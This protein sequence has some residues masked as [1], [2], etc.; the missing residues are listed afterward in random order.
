MLG[1]KLARLLQGVG[2]A[3]PDNPT[4]QAPANSTRSSQAAVINGI[5]PKSV[6]T[7]GSTGSPGLAR[8]ASSLPADPTTRRSRKRRWGKTSQQAI[9]AKRSR[10]ESGPTTNKSPES[11]AAAGKLAEELELLAA[12][13][14]KLLGDR[15]AYE[16][17]MDQLAKSRRGCGAGSSSSST[18]KAKLRAHLQLLRSEQRGESGDGEEEDEDQGSS[19]GEGSQDL[20][21][22]G[23]SGRGSG[24]GHE[25]ET[26]RR[27]DG[28]DDDESDDE[29]ED[30]EEDQDYDA[31]GG[32]GA[33][34]K[35]RKGRGRGGGE[36]S[37]GGNSDDHDDEEEEEEEEEEEG[38]GT[39]APGVSRL[40]S[41]GG[42]T[43][44]LGVDT[45]AR[46]VGRELSDAEVAMLA[47]AGKC[48]Y[49]DAPSADE[50]HL[51]AWGSNAKW[52]MRMYGTS[53]A[54]KKP[55]KGSQPGATDIAALGS[56]EAR[57]VGVSAVSMGLTELPPAPNG[58]PE[59][60]VKERLVSRWR[61]VRQE[62]KARGAAAAAAAAAAAGNSSSVV[63]SAGGAAPGGRALDGGD[64]CS[65]QQRSLF[66][67][68]NSYADVHL[69]GRPYPTDASLDAPDPLLDAVLLHCLNHV[70]KT[71]DRIKKNTHSLQQQQQLLERQRVLQ[72]Q[73]Q[74]GKQKKNKKS[75]Q[76]QGQGQEQEQEQQEREEEMSPDAGEVVRKEVEV[77]AADEGPQTRVVSEP[78]PGNQPR[79][80]PGQS[81]GGGFASRL[82]PSA[83]TPRDQGFTRPK[84]LLLLPQR[85]C[86]FRAVRRLVALA[87]KETRSDSVQGKQ[88]FVEQFMD[89]EEG[90][91]AEGN[92]DD[93]ARARVAA[94]PPEHRALFSGNVDDH[95]R[96]GI[97]V[98]KGA[99][100]LFADLYNSDI[101][102]ASPIALATKLAEDK[103]TDPHSR[104][105][106]LS[107]IEILVVDRADV[108]GMQNWA[109]VETVVSAL[110]QLPREQHGTDIMRVRDWYLSGLSTHYRQTLIL[111]AFATPHT[112]A[113]ARA[114]SNHGGALRLAVEQ[115]GVLSRVVP[116]VRQLFERFPATSP[117][118]AGDARFEFFMGVVWPRVRD[119]VSR[120]LLLFIP[121]Y[122]DFVRLRNA[123]KADDNVD[124]AV[125]SEYSSTVEV[126]RARGRFYHGHRRML[127]YTE[128]A[129]FYN[130]FRIRGIKD[131][132][133]Y[134]LPD[135]CEYY[136][137][138]VNLLEEA[139]GATTSHGPHQATVTAL[140]C[141][142]DV[143]QL[144]RVVGS[145]RANRMLKGESGT[146]MFC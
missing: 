144:E 101:I 61:E 77:E 20:L 121:S 55:G 76:G 137:E 32:P 108:M 15:S 56:H 16:V 136:S 118:A 3:A 6:Q 110:N 33:G 119:T 18:G 102:V 59:Y 104:P 98:T 112:N 13:R 44:P 62:D 79:D 130:R 29:G 128:R 91:Q 39:A 43:A 96:L 40:G 143:M 41:E 117:A 9:I 22:R 140:F 37:I 51:T 85:N 38:D 135:H 47:A 21:I 72:Q 100:R 36:D 87:I 129:H 105:D 113:L 23:I 139:G 19:G 132:L 48:G 86:A 116:Q 67:L 133:F 145:G 42:A 93:A 49:L 52:Q 26:G 142:W 35:E 66:A 90:E 31:A 107:S 73:E 138:L 57:A 75:G 64:F 58:L 4:G 146:Y 53:G 34:L 94:Q 122:F 126:L 81:E 97:K 65:P 68:L 120:G 70:A 60:G 17:L 131:L 50:L 109:H 125:I 46:H 124:F 106:Y 103:A 54:R 74:K 11:T 92:P 78:G 84:V 80:G 27:M 89:P 24:A 1:S 5:K 134:G 141:P 45:W 114:G 111:A 127:L 88:R 14:Q 123:L 99:I 7:N 115:P 82:V 63:A 10:R 12:E 2:G 25:H 28:D 8:G 83:C 30:E 71:A 95:F 69:P